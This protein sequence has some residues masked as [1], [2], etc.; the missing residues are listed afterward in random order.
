MAQV[1]ILSGVYADA[2]ADF[3]TSYPRNYVPVPKATGIA[4]GYLRPAEGIVQNGTGPGVSRGAT[5]WRGTLYRVLGTKLCTVSK[6]GAVTVLGDVGGTGSVRM[7]YGFDRLAIASGGKLFYWDGATLTQVTDADLGNVVDVNWIAGYYMTTDGTNLVIT[8]L[9]DP[10]AVNPLKYGSAESSPDPILAVDELRNEAYAFGRYT[11][12]VF[13]N[14]GGNFFPFQTIP[15]AQIAKG[16]IGTRMY[17]GLGNTFSFTGS[18][19]GE[20]PAVYK[21]VPGDVEKISTREID[22]ILLTYSESV[23]SACEMECRVDKSHQW[24]LIHLPD[25]CLVYDTM[26]SKQVGEHIWFTLDSGV[27]TPSAYRGRHFVWCYDQWNVADPT[28]T[29]LG[30]C[31]DAVASHYGQVIGWEVGTLMLYNEGN[32]AIVHELELVTLPGR[33]AFGDDPVVWTSW[34]K[35]GRV[36]SAERPK[37]TGKIGETLKRLLWRAQ[38]MFQHFRVQKFRG[39]SDAMLVLARLEVKVEGLN[40]RAGGVNG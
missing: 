23:L 19:Q 35:D 9:N 26:A 28:S 14:V 32:G 18:G 24:V 38:G 8:E 25:R 11:I 6:T 4:Q 20:A 39:T 1:P 33:A 30:V 12:E 13:S 7:T 10:T 36:W 29:A 3:R 22:E 16:V 21:V 5:N 17:C 40:T 15:G 27:M 34:S 2:Q 31:S 37:R